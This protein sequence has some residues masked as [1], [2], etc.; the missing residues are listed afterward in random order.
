MQNTT[1][2]T[3]ASYYVA[4]TL[5]AAASGG[6]AWDPQDSAGLLTPRDAA[7][8]ILSVTFNAVPAGYYEIKVCASRER[9]RE[10]ETR[11]RTHTHTHMY[12]HTHTHT[13]T[14]THTHQLTNAHRC[15]RMGRGSEAGAAMDWSGQ[16][17]LTSALRSTAMA[18]TSLCSSTPPPTTS[19]AVQSPKMDTL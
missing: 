13:H 15:A 11:V 2:I 10:R 16:A 6:V 9:K 4:G 17:A 1:T 3:T 18:Q 8:P 19:H 12:T 14:Y 7:S 5:V